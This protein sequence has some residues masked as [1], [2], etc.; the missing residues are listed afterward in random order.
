MTVS[1]RCHSCWSR[2]ER[3][4]KKPQDRWS[5]TISISSSSR[6]VIKF[7]VKCWNAILNDM[8]LNSTLVDFKP[9]D[10]MNETLFYK[11]NEFPSNPFRQTSPLVWTG[12]F[13]SKLVQILPNQP[14]N[15]C[16]LQRASIKNRLHSLS[17]LR[18]AIGI[19]AWSNPLHSL[20]D[21]G[22]QHSR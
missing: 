2:N 3:A 5:S 18:R 17:S 11:L 9:D 6:S 7:T 8:E 15:M 10:N 4:P 16:S 12:W 21:R 13:R 14:N 20:R 1:P 22:H 19:V